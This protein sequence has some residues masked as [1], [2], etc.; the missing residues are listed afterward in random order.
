MHALSTYSASTGASGTL[1]SWKARSSYGS[2]PG[3]ARVAL[4]SARERRAYLYMGGGGC[5]HS[6]H[7]K[8]CPRGPSVTQHSR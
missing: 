2:M 5:M 6:V 4:R 3:M 8:E 1:P 7:T